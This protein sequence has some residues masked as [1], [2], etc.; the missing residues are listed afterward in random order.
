[1]FCLGFGAPQILW[2]GFGW[3]VWCSWVWVLFCVGEVLCRVSACGFGWVV[4]L[5]CSNCLPW[6]LLLL[7]G[8]RFDVLGLCE[9]G[10]LV[11]VLELVCGLG[12]CLGLVAWWGCFAFGTG[13]RVW[14]GFGGGGSG[15]AFGELILL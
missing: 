15:F 9:F 1:M 6:V 8:C 2:V 3:A 14:F 11:C 13:R 5:G 4:V 7:V 10:W 12:W